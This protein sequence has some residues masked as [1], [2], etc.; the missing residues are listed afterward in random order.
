[1]IR[2]FTK[3]RRKANI[4]DFVFHELRHTSTTSMAETGASIIAV[5][6]ILGHADIKTAM[7]YFQPDKSL[8]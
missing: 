5:K 7:K 8:H 1:L 3:A 6:E 2:T 4:K